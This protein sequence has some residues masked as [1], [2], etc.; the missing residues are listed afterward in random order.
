MTSHC[1]TADDGHYQGLKLETVTKPAA[2]VDDNSSVDTVSK[3]DIPTSAAD[4]NT[5]LKLSW[6]SKRSSYYGK[7][8]LRM[9][10]THAG[11]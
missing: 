8:P 9:D 6:A 1:S 5:E 2:E 11:S 3:D 7:I 4:N 10:T